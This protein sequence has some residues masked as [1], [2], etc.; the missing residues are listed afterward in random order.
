MWDNE[1]RARLAFERRLVSR[2]MPQFTFFNLT[3]DTYVSGWVR[4]NAGNSY[5]IEVRLPSDYPD[6]EPALYVTCPSHLYMRESGT[7][8][9][10]VGNSH[11]F[12][13]RSSDRGCVKIC[14]VPDW[15]PSMSCILVLL[16]AHLWLEAYEAYCRTG[17]PI[18][19]F[20]T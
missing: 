7:T 14:H 19:E 17:R 11:S 4:T 3:G 16:K 6:G 8:I 9:N 1:Q 12:H 2:D 18:C 10:S 20:L 15:N 13:T 5:Q